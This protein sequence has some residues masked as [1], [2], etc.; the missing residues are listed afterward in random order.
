MDVNLCVGCGACAEKCPGKFDDGYNAGLKQRTAIYV[1]YPQ[2]VPLKYA[3]NPNVCLKLTKDKCGLCEE[4]CPANAIDYTQKEER[5]THKT[6]N[7]CM[8]IKAVSNKTNRGIVLITE[9][10]QQCLQ[11]EK[12]LCEIQ[13]IKKG[14]MY[15]KPI[16]KV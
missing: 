2:A 12:W 1:E 6:Y 16:S 13:K 4:V 3:I 9:K 5:I 14:E 10:L 11:G 8:V 7:E 15:L